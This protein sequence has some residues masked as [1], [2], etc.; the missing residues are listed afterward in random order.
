M[1]LASLEIPTMKKISCITLILFF[2]LC[3]FTSSEAQT[4]CKQSVTDFLKKWK[5][6]LA[7]LGNDPASDAKRDEHLV[8]ISQTDPAL[9]KKLVKLAGEGQKISAT[10]PQWPE[11]Y[12]QEF[13]NVT[14]NDNN[15]SLSLW[16]A[17]LFKR[18]SITAFISPEF[19]KGLGFHLDANHGAADLGSTTETYSLAARALISYTFANTSTGTGG[20]VRML[21]GVSTYYQNTDFILFV[22]PRLEFRIADVAN[23]IT[24][25]GNVKAIIDANFGETWIIGGGAGLELHNFGLQLLYQRQGDDI[26][27]HLLLGIFYRFGK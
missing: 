5:P 26:D 17:H 21:A 7:E 13:G 9:Y 18:F 20:R 1:A 3:A 12:Q 6:A 16:A 8:E 14:P 25:L 15:V 10:D 22:N 27:S 2:K 23:K 24:S 4:T 11:C 19:E